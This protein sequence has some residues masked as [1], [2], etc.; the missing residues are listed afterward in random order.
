M[1]S[2]GLA[3]QWFLTVHEMCV[4][5]RERE[6]KRGRERELSHVQLF[7][8]RQTPLSMEFSRQEYRIGFPFPSPGDLPN[9]G[10]EPHFLSLLR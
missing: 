5:V 10:M 6:T 2:C 7:V 1:G 4:C 3:C 9:L 8:V